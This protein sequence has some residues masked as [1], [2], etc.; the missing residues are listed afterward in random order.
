[1][2]DTHS[3]ES[4][5][6]E[7]VSPPDAGSAANGANGV[8]KASPDGEDPASDESA[9]TS[10]TLRAAWI[11]RATAIVACAASLL[12]VLVAPG[13]PGNATGP[14]VEACQDASDIF[15]YAT[16]GLLMALLFMGSYELARAPRIA[17]APRIFAVGAAGL[18]V[19]LAAPAMR[20]KLHP[21]AAIFLAMASSVVAL[22]NGWQ[23]LRSQHTR[24]VGAVIIAM[25]IA[26]TVR[27]GAW[28]LASAAGERS[29]TRLYDIASGIASAGVVLE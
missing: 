23:A 27:L 10:P 26:S 22:A 13:M 24:A 28:E 21:V 19:A 16:A 5:A 1:M 29:S 8:G 3:P 9:P 14:I 12:G 17:L 25:A 7:P 6:D 18:V 15:A 2:E 4:A 20:D 11:L